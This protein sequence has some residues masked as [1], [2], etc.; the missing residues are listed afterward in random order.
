MAEPIQLRPGTPFPPILPRLPDRAREVLDAVQQG[1]MSKEEAR[2]YL[3][4]APTLFA[5]IAPP[6][7]M[8][9]AFP[10]LPERTRVGTAL[11]PWLRYGGRVALG[12]CWRVCLVGIA[13]LVAQSG[14]APPLLLVGVLLV[15]GTVAGLWRLQGALGQAWRWSA[16]SAGVAWIGPVWGS[17]YGHLVATVFII[18]AVASSLAAGRPR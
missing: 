9:Q 16:L 5:P 18:A 17:Q 4:L 13:I 1:V 3:G 10:Q 12:I 8:A 11:H 15:L 14:Y 7:P 2:R 6:R